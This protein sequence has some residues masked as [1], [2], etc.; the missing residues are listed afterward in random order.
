MLAAFDDELMR[1]NVEYQGKRGDGRIA[2]P[3]AIL[4]AP[5][6]YDAWRARKAAEGKPENQLKQ[7]ILVRPPG[8]GPAPVAGC[9]FFDSMRIAAEVR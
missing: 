1:R 8:P 3:R 9:E 2:P 5:G 7:P 6:C 4:L